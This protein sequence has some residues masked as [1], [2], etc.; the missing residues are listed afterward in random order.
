[1]IVLVW[2]LERQA[3]E[4]LW[5]G[6]ILAYGPQLYWPT[7]VAIA[8]I[9][10]FLARDRTAYLMT[11]VLV[12]FLFVFMLGLNVP[13]PAGPRGGQRITVVT[14]NVYNQ[15]KHADEIKAEIE[16]LGP[17]VVLL[18]EAMD[19]QWRKT[20]SDW[21][22]VSCHDGWIFTR[23]KIQ[24]GGNIFLGDSWRP[25]SEARIRLGSRSIAVL[26]THLTMVREGEPFWR[27]E[28]N[29]ETRFWWTRE[30]RQRQIAS[31]VDWALRQHMPFILGGDFNTPAN[32]P[33]WRLVRPFAQDAFIARGLGFGYT[34]STTLPLWRID[35]IWASRDFRVLSC[36]TFGDKPS[37]HRG[38]CAELELIE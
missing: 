31:S 21:Q 16:R 34:F 23:G 7:P 18:Q 10:A 27:F 26:N 5:L 32:S 19:R 38:V 35:Y 14:W 30:T 9:A 11:I 15:Y 29:D 37:D 28:G 25:A 24:S 8:V 22:G 13:I 12:V 4:T 33:R 20:F 36:K 6:A 2:L 17:D 3:A 1:L